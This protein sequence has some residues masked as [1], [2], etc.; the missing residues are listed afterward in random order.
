MAGTSA[1]QLVVPNAEERL[2]ALDVEGRLL[3]DAA[4]AAGLDAPVP[5]CPGWTVATLVRHVGL[6]HAWAAD[7]VEVAGPEVDQDAYDLAFEVPDDLFGWARSVHQ[8]LVEA[9][10]ASTDYEGWT[11]FPMPM[12]TRD[13]WIR[14]QLHET[15]VHRMDAELAAGRTLTSMGHDLAADG[16]DELMVGLLQYSPLWDDK[17]ATIA[18]RLG[19]GFA[20]YVSIVAGP[21]SLGEPTAP[22]LTLSGA[23]DDLY[24]AVENRSDEGVTVEGD[25]ELLT[26]WRRAVRISR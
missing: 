16:I 1:H 17:P 2:A 21:P 8:R 12:S 3:L 4:E 9:L 22:D 7:V 13:F 14:R 5:S 19:T 20:W 18:I 23:A 10:R 15:A 26:L 25:R 6:V 11:L 24:A